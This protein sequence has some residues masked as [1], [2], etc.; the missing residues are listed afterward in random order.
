MLIIILLIIL[1]IFMFVRFIIN[2][3][4]TIYLK[5]VDNNFR[6]SDGANKF[7]K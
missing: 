4:N 3:Y 6:F 2:F 1:L 5:T 7:E